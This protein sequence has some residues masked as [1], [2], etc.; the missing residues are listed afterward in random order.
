MKDFFLKREA[1]LVLTLIEGGF[2]SGIKDELMSRINKNISAKKRS[3]LIVPEQ[4]TVL[5]EWE[6]AKGCPG[7][8]PLY[9][10]V[11]NFTR[12]ANTAFRT[13]GGIQKAYA[14][15]TR[16]ALI[17]WQTLTELSPILNMTA[18]RK[19][20]SAGLVERSLG[21]VKEAEA[22]GFDAE[23]L[24]SASENAALD[25]HLSAKLSDLAKISALYKS[26]LGERYADTDDDCRAL[27]KSLKEN[28]DYLSDTEI[29][30]DGFTSFTVPQYALISELL[31]H[32]DLT[33]SLQIPK[34]APSAFE[35]TEL[36]KT[37]GTLTALADKLGADKKVFK[38]D[39]LVGI[40]SEKLAELR[41]LLWKTGARID[42]FKLTSPDELRIFEARTPFEECEFI[43]SDIRRRVMAGDMYKDFAIVLGNP[44]DYEG[45]LDTG[46]DK[47]DIVHFSSAK[48]KLTT[49][50]AVKLIFAA[51]SAASTFSRADISAYLASGLSGISSD[52]RDEFLLYIDKWQI[53]G[54]R[55]TDGLIW[56]MN[57]LGF[58]SRKSADHDEVLARINATRV[59]LTSPLMHLSGRLTA[60]KT[61]RDFAL[62]TFRFIEEIELEA[63]LAKRAERLSE[64]GE[65]TA[66]L[67]NLKLYGLICRALDIMVD[68]VGES[69]ADKDSFSA[70]LKVVFSSLELGRIPSALDE[71]MIGSAD[72]LRTV[73]KKHIYLLGV[74]YGKFPAP[75]DDNSFF[76][77]RDREMLTRSG[78]D[79]GDGADI[80]TSR[81]LYSFSR[82]FAS[83]SESVTISY[84]RADSGFGTL[85]PSFVIEN[86]VRL[87]DGAVKPQKIADMLPRDKFYSSDIARE[88]LG[89]CSESDKKIIK[90]ALKKTGSARV[91]TDS[92]KIE[93]S[94]LTLAKNEDGATLYLTQTAIDT[95]LS[96]PLKYFCQFTLSLSG[97]ERARLGANH[98]G[99]FIH[100]V[101]ENFFSEVRRRGIDL[102]SISENEK[103]DMTRRAA[104]IYLDSLSDELSSEGARTKSALAKIYRAARPVVDGL[105][106]E[107]K[108]SRFT[109]VFFEL[110]ISKIGGVGP[111][112]V[113]ISG[114]GGEQIHIY[115]TI[116]RVDTYTHNGDVYV[117]VV[118]YK[119]GAKS[120]SPERT[121]E[122]E[123]LQMFLYLKSVLEC[124][125]ERFKKALGVPEGGRALPAGLIYV[126]TDIN[127]QKVDTP[128]D[129]S[130]EEAVK[131]AQKRL[132]MVL[133]EDEIFAAFGEEYLPVKLTKGGVH[134]S[135]EKFLFTRDG[136]EKISSDVESA[137]AKIG[138]RI[139]G[140]EIRA[141]SASEAREK[142]SCKY[143][144]FKAF[145]RSLKL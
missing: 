33:V 59:K 145:C 11:S 73:G 101:L 80:R 41:P 135:Y 18:R 104:S 3:V 78:I 86:I 10:E 115:G 34:S 38:R 134:K 117:R 2:N 99:S 127:D 138:H 100:A 68:T 109:P 7:C 39:G 105:C 69:Q 44:S 79:A 24:L 83:A 42:N 8:A 49:F 74:N 125:D 136:W 62:G 77:D 4:E 54:A 95:F 76:T 131:K 84:C 12:F 108:K 58:E 16:K 128:S 65:S 88:A 55:F 28:K 113:K 123:N 89:E 92:E 97:G 6:A 126:K 17:M 19:E 64:I 67:D 27:I 70:E 21:A 47:A 29:F 50:E 82:A 61:I 94:T 119:T 25:G 93:N 124:D 112:P 71:V 106:E 85:S 72:M 1:R 91:F 114:E 46:L 139:A 144:K 122:G 137:V 75:K 110:P 142:S 141:A 52:E 116:D 37:R 40:K 13:L 129:S 90:E 57:P 121:A 111:T 63:A 81:A 143:C 96:C 43:A 51:L 5:A 102:S 45:I 35:Y 118:D 31:T 14:D 133:A 23:V 132:G 120:F 26:K 98:I 30:I 107:F 48:T 87:T 66:A 32:T 140:G 60:A 22:L 130:A 36:T 9:F 20:I 103:A 15:G 53:S 56:N